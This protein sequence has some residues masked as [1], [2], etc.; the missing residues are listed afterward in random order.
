[1]IFNS[2][3]FLIFFPVVVFLYFVIPE[4]IRPFW[5]LLASYYFYMS[6]N[7]WYG[8]LIGLITTV[9]YIAG[10]LMEPVEENKKKKKL[11]L[12]VGI[13]FCLAL[14]FFFKYFSFALN[15]VCRVLS[16]AGSDCTLTVPDIILPVGI[17]FYTFQAISYIVDVYRKNIPVERNF[18]Q[19]ALFVGFFPQLLSGPIGRAGKLLPQMH[20]KHEFEYNRVRDGL[21]L[22]L[23]GFFEKLIIAERAATIVDM[24]YDN[25]MGYSGAAIVIATL[26]FAVQIYC[27]FCGYSHIAVG[28]ARVMGFEL[29]D[30]F[31][32]PYFAVSVQDFWRRWHISLST[33]FRDYVYIPLGGSRC[34][35]VRRYGNIMVTFLAS[36]LWHGASW[37]YVVWGGLNGA[38]QVMEDLF[39]PVEIWLGKHSIFKIPAWIQRLFRGIVTFVLVD[40]AW[41]FFRAPGFRDAIKIINRIRE[42]FLFR[43]FSE[44]YLLGLEKWDFWVLMVA[45][46]ILFLVD[47]LREK[48][49]KILAG[50]ARMPVVLRWSFYL[51]VCLLLILQVMYDFGAPAS[52]FIYFQF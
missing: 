9:T 32:Q 15:S 18:L 16:V 28:A 35:K 10:R 2:F 46:L 44:A 48:K 14:L 42:T 43:N 20:A 40:F 8:L 11:W 13:L 24:V 23:F 34:S 12:A 7:P 3:D 50:I 51:T 47:V 31:M 45:I 22:M 17:S 4:K 27:D 5:L 52:E 33:W 25:Y 36:G 37:H 1:M 29:T 19:Y 41:I 39:R 21:L 38:F 49:I 6:W 26:L 30:N